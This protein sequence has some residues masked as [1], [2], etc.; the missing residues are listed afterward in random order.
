[1]IDKE[2]ENRRSEKL[3]GKRRLSSEY[4]EDLK[5]LLKINDEREFN[6]FLGIAGQELEN[7]STDEMRLLWKKEKNRL[8][9]KKSRDKK[10]R[11]MNELENK[12]KN[13]A[14]HMR[15]L[16]AFI[17]EYEVIL[18]NVLIFVK[19]ALDDY[20][21]SKDD[22]LHKKTMLDDLAYFLRRLCMMINNDMYMCRGPEIDATHQLRIT[23]T[24]NESMHLINEILEPSK[25][26][27]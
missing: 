18:E 17:S 14:N 19:K 26:Y 15:K 25:Y 4:E 13:L 24:I 8:A 10:A 12:E 3:N 21:K 1:M 20:L 9:A 16:N 2:E 27:K 7:I 22:K 11:Y 23:Q 5:K 6:R